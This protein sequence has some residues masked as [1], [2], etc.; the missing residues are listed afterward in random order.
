MIKKHLGKIFILSAILLIGASVAYNQLTSESAN[1]GVVFDSQHVKGNEDAE[2]VL[3][4]Y[5]DFQCVACAQLSFVVND[6]MDTFGE[7][8]R[9]EYRHFPLGIFPHSVTVARAVE[10]AGQ[11]GYFYEMHDM[12]FM[13]QQEWSGS[14]NP[15]PFLNR[16]A[17][18][19]GLDIRTFNRHMRASAI[20]EHIMNGQSEAR[21]LGLTVTPTFILNGSVMS[22]NTLEEFYEQIESSI[23]DSLGDDFDLESLL[24]IDGDDD[25]F[26]IN[27]VNDVESGGVDDEAEADADSRNQTKEEEASDTAEIPTESTGQSEVRFGF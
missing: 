7:L 24:L 26:D 23:I 1:E 27:I 22:Y 21:E 5:S 2:V 6:I 11:Q 19:I 10:A 4:K 25:I 9:F 17:E 16:Y 15:R 20:R 18:E 14:A 13:R 3:L 12:V 8:I